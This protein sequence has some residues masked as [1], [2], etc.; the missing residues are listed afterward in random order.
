MFHHA[1]CKLK[2]SIVIM[3]HFPH[4]NR[5]HYFFLRFFYF[6][7]ENYEATNMTPG[8]ISY[9]LFAITSSRKLKLQTRDSKLKTTTKPH[10][11]IGF[12]DA[13]DGCWGRIE[14]VTTL[15]CWLLWSPTSTLFLHPLCLWRRALTFK[16]CH[17]DRN[18]VTN[19]KKLSLILNH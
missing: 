7:R 13:G 16:R 9:K 6:I 15:R 19:I 4:S 2:C 11:S 8:T 18:S 10:H 5:I 1:V 17:Q 3:F 14:L 12:I